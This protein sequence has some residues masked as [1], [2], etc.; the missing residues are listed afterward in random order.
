MRDG[1]GRGETGRGV[2][3][4]VERGV[5]GGAILMRATAEPT[6][7]SCDVFEKHSNIQEAYV[8]SNARFTRERFEL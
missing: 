7:I 3:G 5:R 8:A 2:A 1:A 4:L 6:N